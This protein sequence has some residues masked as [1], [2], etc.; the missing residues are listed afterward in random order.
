MADLDPERP[1]R[2]EK[3]P[4]VEALLDF[5][6]QPALANLEELAA[7]EALVQPEFP[8]RK[9]V[10]TW[11]GN[12]DLRED[13]PKLTV[14][15]PEVKGFAFW[16]PDKLRVIQ[17]RVDGFSLSHLAPYDKW[18]TLRDDARSWWEKFAHITKPS[19]VTRYALRFINRV[20]L[21]LP[22]KDFSD[23]LRTLPTVAGH[24]PQGLSSVFMRL[25]VPFPD[26]TVVITQAIDET[27]VTAETVPVILDIDVSQLGPVSPSG[28]ELWSRL[29]S[30][31]RIKND[32]FFES[33]TP[34]AWR[35][36]E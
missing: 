25:V 34:A 33:L 21:P 6:V 29:E 20:E 4:V 22:M 19:A 11:Q 2:F 30:L 9:R 28:D 1:E 35:L 23:Y 24:L 5:H 13:E 36:F 27:G 18:S 16:T 10:I 3:A 8:E 32:V 7:F 26:A 12:F 15:A 14:P 31:R 17:A